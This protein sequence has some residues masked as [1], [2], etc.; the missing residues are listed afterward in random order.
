VSPAAPK[1]RQLDI[2]PDFHAQFSVICSEKIKY[3]Y[4]G[5][6][7]FILITIRFFWPEMWIE[8]SFIMKITRI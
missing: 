2:K 4:N 3:D 5:K 1:Y 8:L 6:Y 7:F